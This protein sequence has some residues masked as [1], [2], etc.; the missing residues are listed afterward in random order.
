[1]F[2][3]DLFAFRIFNSASDES[4]DGVSQTSSVFSFT[5]LAAA[6]M[7]LELDRLPDPEKA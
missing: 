4:G 6:V 7:D 2:T 3:L 1:M 5:L